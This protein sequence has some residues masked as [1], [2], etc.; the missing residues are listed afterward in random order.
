MF[1][2]QVV[3]EYVTSSEWG[4]HGSLSTIILCR[5]QIRFCWYPN[6][7]KVSAP[8][9]RKRR[10]LIDMGRVMVLV[11]D[12]VTEQKVQGDMLDVATVNPRVPPI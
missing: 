3:S 10:R 11:A 5:D 9:F 4:V 2:N 7:K 1:R 6:F 8:I 12:W